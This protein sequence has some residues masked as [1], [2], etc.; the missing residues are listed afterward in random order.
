MSSALV[1]Q[2]D[3]VVEQDIKVG[4]RQVI[5]VAQQE[6]QLLIKPQQLTR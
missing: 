4:S 6:R 5:E 2:E 1:E 3:E